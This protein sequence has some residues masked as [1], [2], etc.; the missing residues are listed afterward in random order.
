ML[1]EDLKQPIKKQSFAEKSIIL[2][3]IFGARTI[4]LPGE[5]F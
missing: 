4:T 5:K 3:Q 1:N 2:S